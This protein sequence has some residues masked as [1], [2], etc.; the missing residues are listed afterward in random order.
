MVSDK[1]EGIDQGED[2]VRSEY[3]APGDDVSKSEDCDDVGAAGS[4][5]ANVDKNK[6]SVSENVPKQPVCIFCKKNRKKHQGREQPLHRVENEKSLIRIGQL[7][8]DL[9]DIA[10]IDKLHDLQSQNKLMFYHNFCRNTYEN[11]RTSKK[12]KEKEKTEWHRTRNVRSAA[13]EEVCKLTDYGWREEDNKF[14]FKWFDGDQLPPSLGD[15][16]IE[17]EK[18]STADDEDRTPMIDM[19]YSDHESEQE[20]EGDDEED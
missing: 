8:L 15:I 4:A 1:G 14:L 13:Y 9:D 16:T 6:D 11:S 17:E 10:L 20:F 5:D 3:H 7:A 2:N 12:I 18:E 19:D